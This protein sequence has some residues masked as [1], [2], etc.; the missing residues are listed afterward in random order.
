MDKGYSK[1]VSHERILQNQA[2]LKYLHI[3][4]GY[5]INCYGSVLLAYLRSRVVP[6]IITNKKDD[7]ACVYLCVYGDYFISLLHCAL[8]AESL[9]MRA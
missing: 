2:T 8:S 7:L 6:V 5:R 9:K 4:K 3:S 1:E